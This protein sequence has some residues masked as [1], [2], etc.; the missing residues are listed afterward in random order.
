MKTGPEPELHLVLCHNS[1]RGRIA[2]DL[3]AFVEFDLAL[4][5]S[6]REL[7]AKSPYTRPI[8]PALGRISSKPK[9]K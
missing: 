3:N 9:P 5:R 7:V 2:V 4:T 8:Q 6:L 1:A